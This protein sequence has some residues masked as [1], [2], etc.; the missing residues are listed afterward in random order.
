MPKQT[1]YHLPSEKRLMIEAAL[2]DVFFEQHISQVTVTQ[3]VEKTGISRAAFYKYFPTLEDAHLYMI[4]KI[5]MTIHQDILRYI[6]ENERDFFGGIS[7][8]LRYCGELDH[9]SDYWKG[10]KLLIKGENTIMHQRMSPT[11][12][13]EMSQEWLGILERN[14][15]QITDSEE[16]I[17]FLYFVMDIVID[18]LTAFIVNDW[19]TEELLKEF[20]YKKKWLIRGIK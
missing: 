12:D 20:S 17:C 7:E 1:F 14:G 9:K 19:A 13:S 4:K 15:F 18:S 8:Y 10:L 11:N 6:E 3:I 5:A 16:A 2:L